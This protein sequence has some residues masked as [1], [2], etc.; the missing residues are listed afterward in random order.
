MASSTGQMGAK[1]S[2]NFMTNM[3]K[4]HRGIWPW[5][6]GL[7]SRLPFHYKKSYVETWMR[8]PVPVHYRP[9]TKKFIADKFGMPWRVQDTPIPITFPRE[10]DLGLWGGEGIIAGF[11]KRENNIMKPR[12]ASLWK[13]QLMSRVLYSDILDRWM[14]LTV[15]ART[16]D[17][18]DAAYGFDMYILKT[19]EV[20]LKS[21]LGMT[22]KREML[23]TLFRR[24]MYPGDLAKKDAIF[25]KYKEFVIAEEEAEWIGLS[26]YEAEQ[27][28]HEVEEARRELDTL[29]KK[30]AYIEAL[31]EKLKRASVAAEGLGE[32]SSTTT[33]LKKLSPFQKSTDK[34][35]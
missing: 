23:L 30:F 19:H 16:L 9:T 21:K 18:I 12:A 35:V 33:W 1:L 25:E 24:S 2:I 3:Q 10:A 6:V 32:E 22:L 27:K 20:D 8:E 31:G 14:E 29:P 34:T 15:T 13:P 26:L 5:T 28:Q 17:L 11:K 7:K 4:L